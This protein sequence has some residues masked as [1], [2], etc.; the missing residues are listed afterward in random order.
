MFNGLLTRVWPFIREAEV[1][2]IDEDKRRAGGDAG[3][4]R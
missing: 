4:Y 2:R 3:E 1:T